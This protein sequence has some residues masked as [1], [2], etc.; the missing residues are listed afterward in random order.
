MWLVWESIRDCAVAAWL[1]LLYC[2]LVPG[3]SSDSLM[4]SHSLEQVQASLRKGEQL[5]LLS[6]PPRVNEIIKCV[7][8]QISKSIWEQT[9][10][11]IALSVDFCV[12]PNFEGEGDEKREPVLACKRG[13]REKTG[14]GCPGKQTGRGLQ[15]VISTCLTHWDCCDKCPRAT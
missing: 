2:A 8:W 13:V 3:L 9:N 10:G 14:R 5:L 11:R 12:D 15:R 6:L 1:A 4:E 7:D